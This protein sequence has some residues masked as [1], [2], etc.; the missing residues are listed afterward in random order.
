MEGRC[1]NCGNQVWADTR[2][3]TREL[4][5]CPS[6]F[7]DN[8]TPATD[9]ERAADWRRRVD[10]RMRLTGETFDVAAVIVPYGLDR[11]R[12]YEAEVA[13]MK[14]RTAGTAPEGESVEHID[15]GTSSR[16]AVLV[17]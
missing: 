6:C 12:A 13:R 11:E 7:T 3:L 9:Q 2:P 15:T 5:I 8:S 17:R 16:H 14:A 4:V 1:K 10:K